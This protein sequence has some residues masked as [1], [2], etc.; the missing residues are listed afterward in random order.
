[1][2]KKS[3]S[4]VSEDFLRDYIARGGKVSDPETGEELDAD[5]IDEALKEAGGGDQ[6][7][8]ESRKEKHEQAKEAAPDAR[9]E[10]R[11]Q[12][13]REQEER[14]L[15][16]EA[17][18]QRAARQKTLRG[19]ATSA[20]MAITDSGQAAAERISSLS[21]AGGIGLLL[22][23]LTLLVFTVV[24]VN[25]KGDTRLKLLWAMLNGQTQL[26]GRRNPKL[27]GENTGKNEQAM[28]GS[29]PNGNGNGGSPGTLIPLDTFSSY[30]GNAF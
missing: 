11:E 21:T 10:E 2:T 16:E 1:M 18:K 4:E 3:E 22:V 6:A 12:K 29:A 25:A 30:R 8:P 26:E 5:D 20:A 28:T 24:H 14:E 23:I 19:A 27:E 9:A 15:A 7:Q 17:A 13:K